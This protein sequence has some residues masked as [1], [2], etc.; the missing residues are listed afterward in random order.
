MAGARSHW[1][2]V[3]LPFHRLFSN[4]PSL[5]QILL[6]T[7]RIRRRV[8]KRA[9]ISRIFALFFSPL[10]TR[11]RSIRTHRAERSKVT[12]WWATRRTAFSHG[13]LISRRLKLVLGL[14]TRV[15]LAKGSTRIGS[16]LHQTNFRFWI[17]DKAIRSQ[18]MEH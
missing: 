2:V 16:D 5:I 1:F 17:S 18:R 6:L 13:P 8:K 11:A 9:P 4:F 15:I 3:P 14:E 10:T 7:K 12:N